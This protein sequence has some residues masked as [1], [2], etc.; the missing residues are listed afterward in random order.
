M[1]TKEELISE[2]SV[3]TS[4]SVKDNYAVSVDQ[5]DFAS[6]RLNQ[7]SNI[8]PNRFFTADRRRVI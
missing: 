1:N 5:N 4:K 7:E 2:I 6:G 3:I 8:R